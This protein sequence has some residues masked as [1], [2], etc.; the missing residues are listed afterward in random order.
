MLILKVDSISIIA[1]D[2]D[3]S[4]GESLELTGH[5]TVD[6]EDAVGAKCASDV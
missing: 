2:G 1:N 6:P 4:K 5:V 3:V